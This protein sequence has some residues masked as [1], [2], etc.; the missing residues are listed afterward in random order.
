M[1]FIFPAATHTSTTLATQ[2][3]Q[4]DKQI[5]GSN[6]FTGGFVACG[7]ETERTFCPWKQVCFRLYSEM[8]IWT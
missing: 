2:H 5:F 1:K 4:R 6:R 8:Q 7:Q 3:K